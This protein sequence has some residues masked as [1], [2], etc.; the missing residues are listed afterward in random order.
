MLLK[1]CYNQS[2][3][4]HLFIFI[5]LSFQLFI[6]TPIAFINKFLAVLICLIIIF[7][8][9]K[10]KLRLKKW[11]ELFFFGLTSAYLALAFFGF[12]LFLE[13]KPEHLID[14]S[15]YQQY[16]PADEFHALLAMAGPYISIL[17]FGLGLI[18][19]SYVLYFS[20]DLVLYLSETKDKICTS[21]SGSYT[22]KWL[23]LFIILIVVLMVW[24]RAFY[25]IIMTDDSWGYIGGWYSGTYNTGSSPVYAFLLS[26]LLWLAPTK[27]EVEWIAFAQILIFSSLL[28][29]I[30]MYF[31]QRWIRFRY[32]IIAAFIL[33]LIPSLGLHTVVIWSDLPNGMAV[34]W[35]VYALVRILDEVII[36]QTA[37]EKQKRSLCIQL[38][39]SMVFVFFIRAN[40]FPVYLVMAPVLAVLFFLKRQWKLL[41]SVLLSIVI[42]LLIRFPGYNALGVYQHEQSAYHKYLAGIHDLHS[43]YYNGGLLS[44]H[45]ILK[46]REIIP[47]I[48][49]PDTKQDFQPDWVRYLEYDL[50]TAARLSTSEFVSMYA[51]TFFRN[52]TKMISSMLYRVRSYWVIDAKGY[53]N[54]INYTIDVIVRSGESTDIPELN[55]YRKPNFLT[56]IMYYYAMGTSLPLPSIFIWRYGIWTAFMV[57]CIL[58]LIIQRRFLWIIAFLP[59]AVYQ[60]ALYL[61]NAWTDYRYGLP[62]FLVGLFLIPA[63]ILLPHGKSAGQDLTFK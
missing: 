29:T 59:A 50:E 3:R 34:L 47:H 45:T 35:F 48:D 36:N 24:Q 31:H 62:V 38:C 13:P 19:T 15:Y 32:M 5:L 25:P 9:N 63:M 57:I 52:P 44:D 30:L 54:T 18:W 56:K 14:L 1:S 58:T 55:V 23:I 41:S 53:V 49:E 60:A 51:D 33:P 11:Y 10:T 28:A 2:M 12:D 26:I 7:C 17:Y 46:L 4:L 61:T 8:F 40:S 37:G 21:A 20:L 43:T 16:I 39:L 22:K 27:P 6:L 42:I